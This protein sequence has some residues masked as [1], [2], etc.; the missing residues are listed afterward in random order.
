MASMPFIL[1]VVLTL[2][3]TTLTGCL[4]RPSPPRGTVIEVDSPAIGPDGALV[5]S[6]GHF[7]VAGVAS[8]PRGLPQIQV[9][10]RATD[11]TLVVVA[12]DA[13]TRTELPVSRVDRDAS[14]PKEPAP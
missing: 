11:R 4:E 10:F 6:L 5:Q 9:L 2:A 3:G 7:Q 12:I 1:G 13:A 14:P 8:A